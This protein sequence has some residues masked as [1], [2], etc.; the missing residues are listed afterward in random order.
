MCTA[1]PLPAP[2]PRGDRKQADLYL[3]EE[4]LAEPGELPEVDRRAR[5]GQ[6]GEGACPP[7][8]L[9]GPAQ[10]WLPEMSLFT[11]RRQDFLLLEKRAFLQGP[12]GTGEGAGE[13]AG[14]RKSQ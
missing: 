13:R 10:L 11:A 14:Q 9:P 12:R 4:M 8:P 5:E 2:D 7:T 3:P 1:G 6:W